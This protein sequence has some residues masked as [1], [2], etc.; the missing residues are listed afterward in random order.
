M[1]LDRGSD[2]RLG[3]GF[4]L[5]PHSA[6]LLSWLPGFL[7]EQLHFELG[8]QERRKRAGRMIHRIK[9]SCSDVSLSY[10]VLLEQHFYSC[11]S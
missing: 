2:H 10:G 6:S 8:I 7:S 3:E 11:H 9:Q 4:M 5:E 1:Y